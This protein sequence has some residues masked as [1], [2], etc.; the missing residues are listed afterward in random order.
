[1]RLS[2]QLLLF[3]FLGGCALPHPITTYSNKV[4]EQKVCCPSFREMTFVPISLGE[5]REFS[6]DSDT[7][8]F[9]FKDGRSRFAAIQ[10]PVQAEAGKLKLI[11]HVVPIWIEP[12]VFDPYVIF[13]K[14]DYA[15][16]GEIVP[17]LKFKSDFLNGRY[18]E[19]EVSI[20]IG[21]AYAIVYTKPVV[22][23]TPMYVNTETSL[24]FVPGR[25]PFVLPTQ[26]TPIMAGPHGKIFIE[27]ISQ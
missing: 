11:T 3:G 7:P 18:W 24:T 26:A 17:A 22:Y 10:L 5:K 27:V 6:I 25:V 16:L 20:P 13:L 1:M 21:A 9:V 14:Q 19:A 23:L 4:N 12:T 2:G 15:A 8:V